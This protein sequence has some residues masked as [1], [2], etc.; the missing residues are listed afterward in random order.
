MLAMTVHPQVSAS[1][2][3]NLVSTDPIA[4]FVKVAGMDE[5]M[6]GHQIAL[7]Q[8]REDLLAVLVGAEVDR[9]WK[10]RVK[11]HTNVGLR[12]HRFQERWHHQQ[13]VGVKPD[14]LRASQEVLHL[15]DFP[16]NFLVEFFVLRPE[17]DV[18]M[19]DLLDVLEVMEQ[20]A[21]D[22]LVVLE[23]WL[24]LGCRL[25]DGVRPFLFEH[26][27]QLFLLFP[28]VFLDARDETY[29]VEVE[30][31]LLHHVL[32]GCIEHRRVLHR[33]LDSKFSFVVPINFVG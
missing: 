15:H 20:W 6:K 28:A 1:S 2:E 23:G 30:L 31:P 22:V 21:D 7:K 5:Q 18:V 3:F 11:E 29:P 4:G 27:H 8:A 32:E 25:E 33:S 19:P 13:I 9:R 24:Q 12:K 14:F 10:R 26:G 17:L 16:R